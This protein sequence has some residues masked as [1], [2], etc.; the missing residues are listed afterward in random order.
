MTF[1]V[2]Y[3]SHS[4]FDTAWQLFHKLTQQSMPNIASFSH[5][6]DMKATTS[7]RRPLLRSC[8][9][10]G[11]HRWP[12]SDPRIREASRD[13][14]GS[15]GSPITD[16]HEGLYS[17]IFQHIPTIFQLDKLAVILAKS[18]ISLV[19]DY[20]QHVS[21][22]F[23]WAPRLAVAHAINTAAPILQRWWNDL[24]PVATSGSTRVPVTHKKRWWM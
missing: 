3:T 9:F 13:F 4:V 6:E 1:Q 23:N 21:Q 14:P 8:L 16:K 24:N 17:N 10:F 11:C 5:H 12:D 22:W 2:V 20:P 7:Q 19:L 15:A 18:S